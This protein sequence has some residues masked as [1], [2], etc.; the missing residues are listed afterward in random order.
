MNKMVIFSL[1]LSVLV[2]ALDALSIIGLKRKVEQR[3]LQQAD[4]TLEGSR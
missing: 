2:F 4:S 3:R 1:L